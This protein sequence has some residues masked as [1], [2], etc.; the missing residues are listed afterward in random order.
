MSLHSKNANLCI[1][2]WVDDLLSYMLLEEKVGKL[3][4]TRTNGR[5]H[6]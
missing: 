3:H 6:F 5:Q 1:D 4:H 2:A